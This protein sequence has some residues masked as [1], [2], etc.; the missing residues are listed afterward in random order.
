MSSTCGN[1]WSNGARQYRQI[2][3]EHDKDCVKERFK[4]AR[5]KFDR[6]VQ[7]GR[8]VLGMRNCSIKIFNA[9]ELELV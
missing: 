8:E 5:V 3:E 2:D 1:V 6:D 9:S 4:L 7:E